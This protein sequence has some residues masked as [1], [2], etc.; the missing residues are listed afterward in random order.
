MA[1]AARKPQPQYAVRSAEHRHKSKILKKVRENIDKAFLFIILYYIKLR[2]SAEVFSMDDL[3]ELLRQE[4]EL[5]ERIESTRK[6]NKAKAIEQV[7]SLVSM[8][9]LTAEECGFRSSSDE[10]DSEDG[11][12]RLPK[13]LS[14]DGEVWRGI[15][16][17]P[18]WVRALIEAGE[19]LEKYRVEN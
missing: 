12:I 11:I 6:A 15:G 5:R 7:L 3:K 18:N 8:Y 4:A 10:V 13:Y 17:R 19:D 1:A 2:F 14:P 16:R 9:G